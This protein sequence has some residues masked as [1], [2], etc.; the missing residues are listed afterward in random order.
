[1]VKHPINA[2]EASHLQVR[3]VSLAKTYTPSNANVVLYRIDISMIRDGLKAYFWVSKGSQ[4]NFS[5]APLRS[6]SCPYYKA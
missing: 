5:L 4:M 6:K 2:Y 1:M 3:F